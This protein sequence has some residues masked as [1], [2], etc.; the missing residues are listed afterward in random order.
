MQPEAVRAVRRGRWER[1]ALDGGP[2]R[3]R[4]QSAVRAR[5]PQERVDLPLLP[6]PEVA[7]W[8]L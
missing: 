7:G 5:A 1:G 4:R 3:Q 8:R 2:V 6:G